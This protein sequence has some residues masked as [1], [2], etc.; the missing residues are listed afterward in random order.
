MEAPLRQLDTLQAQ[1]LAELYIFQ[2]DMHM[3]II[4]LELWHEK[5]AEKNSRTEEGLI[6]QSLF[7]DAII[8]FVGCF[9][10]SA[11]FAL[12]ANDIYGRY[13]NGLASFQWFQDT[14]DAYAAHKFGAQRQCVVGIVYGPPMATGIGKLMAAY[15]GQK[16]ADGPQLVGFMRSAATHL[17]RKIKEL[18]TNLLASVVTMSSEQIEAL[19]IATVRQLHPSE[20][21]I[22]RPTLLKAL[23]EA[24][25][26]P[27]RKK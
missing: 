6:G 25:L 27:I 3:A 14:R 4:T 11:R 22:S 24:P 10:K 23:K 8:Q 18:E 20:S 13:P 5:Y 17:D 12:S 26:L 16:K 19:K 7:R 2:H 9:D 21:R 1:E 15:K